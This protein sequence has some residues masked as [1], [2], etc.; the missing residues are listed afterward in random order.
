MIVYD[1]SEEN[2]KA[3]LDPSLTLQHVRSALLPHQTL[4]PRVAMVPLSTC[5]ACSAAFSGALRTATRLARPTDRQ[6]TSHQFLDAEYMHEALTTNEL[7]V[8]K[9]AGFARSVRFHPWLP[10]YAMIVFPTELLYAFRSL[11]KHC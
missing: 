7:L 2:A 6:P 4:L 11:A 5:A 9:A 10:D 1:V 8:L 3:S